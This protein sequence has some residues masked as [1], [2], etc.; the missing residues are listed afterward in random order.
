[1]RDDLTRAAKAL[2][3]R[4]MIQQTRRELLRRAGRIGAATAGLALLAGCG[5]VG[6]LAQAPAAPAGPT[7]QEPPPETTTIRLVQVPTICQAPQYVV[8]DLLKSEGFT[9]VQYVKKAGTKGIE[10]ALASGEADVN[11]HFAAPLVLRIDAGDPITVLAGGHVGCFGLFGTG[12]IQAVRDLKGKSVGVSELGASQHVFLSSML[13]Y[14]GVDPRTDVNFIVQPSDIAKEM[15]AAGTVDAYLAFPPDRQE[16]RVKQIGRLVVDST[17][18][19]P[20]SQY[21]CCMIAGN[22]AFVQK[23]PVATRRAVRAILKAADFCSREPAQAARIL[24]DGG[25]TPNYDYALEALTGIPYGKWREYDAEDTV[26]FYSLRLQEVGM[27]KSTPDQILQRGTD[28][29]F[30]NELKQELKA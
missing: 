7:F 16:L 6:G 24:V 11:M 23:N 27:S 9:D 17:V 13:A 22:S 4:R 25:Y 19:R 28:W 14:V 1:L 12:Q 8:E 10:E 15:L 2:K 18:D 20:W 5:V 21:F 30:L 26:R 3:E 29:R